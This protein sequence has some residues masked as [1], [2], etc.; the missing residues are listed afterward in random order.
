MKYSAPDRRLRSYVG[1]GLRHS[2]N[3]I[4]V[5]SP[6]TIT[7]AGMQISKLDIRKIGSY[8]VRA[9]VNDMELTTTNAASE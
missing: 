6:S 4:N 8:N 3:V 7:I 9:S 1:C 2:Y 5:R